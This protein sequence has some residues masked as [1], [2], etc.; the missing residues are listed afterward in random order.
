MKI[1]KLTTIALIVGCA[2]SIT[3]CG[4]RDRG[5]VNRDIKY[6]F[7]DRLPPGC[8]ISYLGAFDVNP[9]N[10]IPL[11]MVRCKAAEATTTNFTYS[12]GKTRNSGVMIQIHDKQIKT[13]V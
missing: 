2:V 5:E 9:L 4:R 6:E 10:R 11:I 12:Q 13:G 8:E 3:G 7:N 1:S